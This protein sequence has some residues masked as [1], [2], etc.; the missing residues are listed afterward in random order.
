MWCALVSLFAALLIALSAVTGAGL[1][2]TKIQDAH[3]LDISKWVMCDA[4]GKDS[5]P[6]KLYQYSQSNDLQFLAFSKSAATSG[7][8]TPESG[9][10]MLL[11]TVGI[12]WKKIINSSSSVVKAP[13]KG[14]A[15]IRALN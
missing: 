3:A 14:Q 2:A 1:G 4:F 5:F 11:K 10:N 9:A 6:A 8:S 13:P 7:R 12:D 15:S